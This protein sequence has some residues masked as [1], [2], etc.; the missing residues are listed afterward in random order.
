[1]TKH[2]TRQDELLHVLLTSCSIWYVI[3]TYR[4][5]ELWNYIVKI[6]DCS[7]TFVTFKNHVDDK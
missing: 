7:F 4:G 5:V 2:M 6:V 3:V 1:M